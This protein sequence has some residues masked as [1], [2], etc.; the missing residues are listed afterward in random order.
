MTTAEAVAKLMEVQTSIGRLIE[1]APT[2][3]AEDINSWIEEIINELNEIEV[4]D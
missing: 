2:D 4:N 1:S 3:E